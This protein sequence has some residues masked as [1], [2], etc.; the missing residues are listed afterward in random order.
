RKHH[1]V[2]DIRHASQRRDQHLRKG[3]PP[4]RQHGGGNVVDGH[5]PEGRVCLHG[6]LPEVRF[7]KTTSDRSGVEAPRSPERQPRRLAHF[8]AITMIS[9][10][11]C[12][13][14]SLA[15][16]VARAGVLPG[17]TQPSHT[18]FISCK[19]FMSVM[20]ILARRSFDLSVPHLAR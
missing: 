14:A 17:D 10:L 13:A 9:T 5:V 16:T 20:Q 3:R 15:S 8:A 2:A 19:V 18:E 11:Y 1:A 7:G 4:D 6:S 12:G